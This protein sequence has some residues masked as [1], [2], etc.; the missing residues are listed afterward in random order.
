MAKPHKAA[1]YICAAASRISHSPIDKVI[2]IHPI[3][4]KTWAST[5]TNQTD[6]KQT[7][8]SLS[9]FITSLKEL[10]EVPAPELARLF[11]LDEAPSFLF[12]LLDAV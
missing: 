3:S 10:A 6:G 7:L 4:K 9:I 1:L 12:D 8:R 11:C 5:E 2:L